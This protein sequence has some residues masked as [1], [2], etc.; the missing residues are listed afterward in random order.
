MHSPFTVVFLNARS[1]AMQ[2]KGS[3]LETNIDMNSRSLPSNHL[4]Q[5]LLQQHIS[6]RA[7][8]V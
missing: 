7:I 5:E 4:H 8:M 3:S 1:L 6:L 2:A